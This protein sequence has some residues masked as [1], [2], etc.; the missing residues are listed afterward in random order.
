MSPALAGGFFTISAT[1]ED[2]ILLLLLLLGRFSHVRLCETPETEPTRLPSPWDSPGKNTA[3]P[4]VVPFTGM[5]QGGL[6]D[7][8]KITII[9][10]VLPSG[11][12]RYRELSLSASPRLCAGATRSEK[13][14]GGGLRPK[15]GPTSHALGGGLRLLLTDA[16]RVP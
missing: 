9:G 11:G 5:I 7:G 13:A 16:P 10:T 8:H 6:Q 1:W 2:P 4:Q 14:L 12:N 15:R 3:S